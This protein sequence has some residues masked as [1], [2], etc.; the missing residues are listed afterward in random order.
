MTLLNERD[1]GRC[2]CLASRGSGL[3]SSPCTGNLLHKTKRDKKRCLF[4][5]MDYQSEALADFLVFLKAELCQWLYFQ[6]VSI[7]SS[8]KL[9]VNLKAT[10]SCHFPLSSPLT[11]KDI[12]PHLRRAQEAAQ[13]FR[14][15][16]SAIAPTR[17]N[18]KLQSSPPD[19]NALNRKENHQH[20]WGVMLPSYLWEKK[21]G[22]QRGM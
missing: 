19:K 15:S 9:H 8:C 18:T 21:S 6:Q 11:V 10:L 13:E 17:A 14:S 1:E 12:C 4:T 16:D 22:F 5:S 3:L 7:R 20:S 2:L